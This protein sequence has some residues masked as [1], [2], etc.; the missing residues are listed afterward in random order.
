[1]NTDFT[2]DFQYKLQIK[3][4]SVVIITKNIGLLCIMIYAHCFGDRYCYIT[5]ENKMIN[6]DQW[7]L[8]RH[9]KG[10]SIISILYRMAM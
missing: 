9:F 7:T 10:E 6:I 4:L 2:I 5:E 8:P 3:G 1:M